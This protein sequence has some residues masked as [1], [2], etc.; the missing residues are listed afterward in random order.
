MFG[1]SKKSE[2]KETRSRLRNLE[3][4]VRSLHK[5]VKEHDA[6]IKQVLE[7]K[8]PPTTVEKVL[9]RE[10]E[11]SAAKIVAEPARPEE[12][13]VDAVNRLL[14]DERNRSSA[15]R[16]K[17]KL[18]G[19]LSKRYSISHR[20]VY[21][22][23]ERILRK[24]RIAEPE[25]R[26]KLEDYPSASV[27][28]TPEPRVSRAPKAAPIP[29]EIP[30]ERP[31]KPAQ[32]L[33]DK[34]GKEVTSAIRTVQKEMRSP[35]IRKSAIKWLMREKRPQEAAS[36]FVNSYYSRHETPPASVNKDLLERFAY[37]PK[38]IEP[39]FDVFRNL[40]RCDVLE[41]GLVHFPELCDLIIK[42]L[43]V[44][45]STARHADLQS[46]MESDVKQL[47]AR[48][49]TKRLHER[50]TLI[51]M[52]SAILK[53]VVSD[54]LRILMTEMDGRNPK[55]KAKEVDGENRY[56]FWHHRFDDD[57]PTKSISEMISEE[58]NI[59]RGVMR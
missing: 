55:L 50:A 25:P 28:R 58:R 42:R 3:T 17:M 23:E 11:A 15:G 36:R 51:H 30:R 33:H 14:L 29:R 9:I 34:Y 57:G 22:T 54:Q 31:K 56:F 16:L 35:T 45:S 32:I 19:K 12:S 13:L 49:T 52:D 10:E 47:I 38:T 53:K 46:L 2:S 41:N 27:T 1:K 43:R 44:V 24:M 26:V 59:R 4:A 48:E 21:E 8:P 7:Q 40:F 18:R 6:L 5:I 37:P 20:Q 39:S